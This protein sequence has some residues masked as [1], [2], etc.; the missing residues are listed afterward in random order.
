MDLNP[1]ASGIVVVFYL[2]ATLVLVSLV[3]ALALTLN[4]LNAKLAEVTEKVEPLLVKA[5]EMMTM[6]NE[7]LGS[8]GDKTES[9]LVQG[10]ETVESVHEKVDRTAIAVQRTIHA[11]II[12]LN[13][14]AAGVAR[15]V[16]TFGRLQTHTPPVSAL[17]TTVV[18]TKVHETPPA[19]EHEPTALVARQG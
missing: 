13:S 14:I 19:G 2:V 9:I 4:K 16:S 10:E 6:A 11:P 8:I 15:G 18:E 12:S 3:A 5:D 7:K 1:V 17:P